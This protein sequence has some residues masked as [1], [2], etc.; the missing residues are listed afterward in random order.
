MT[1][2]YNLHPPFSTFALSAVLF[3]PSMA[4]LCVLMGSAFSLDDVKNGTTQFDPAVC[5]Y[6]MPLKHRK[7][8]LPSEE[9]Q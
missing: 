5:S 6:E 2:F 1:E 4:E 7:L 3:L 8:S 9:V